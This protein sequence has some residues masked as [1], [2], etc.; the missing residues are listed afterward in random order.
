[1]APYY[2]CPNCGSGEDQRGKQMFPKRNGVY[3]IEMAKFG[4]YKVWMADLWECPRCAYQVIAGF[5]LNALAEHY[6]QPFQEVLER[7]KAS[8]HVYYC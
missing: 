4:P 3:V 2:V 1:M 7:A 6:Q 8:D 5:G